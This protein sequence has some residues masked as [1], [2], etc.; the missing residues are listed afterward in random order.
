M[1]SFDLKK[2][3]M[4]K[5]SERIFWLT[6]KLGKN[7][8]YR[9]HIEPRSSSHVPREESCPIPLNYIDVTRSTC[10]DLEVAQEKRIS[11]YRDVDENRNLS[12]SWTNFTIFTLM[13]GT[14]LTRYNKPWERLMKIQTTSR[15]DHKISI[16]ERNSSEEEIYDVGENWRKAETSEAKTNSIVLILQGRT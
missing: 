2:Q 8:I 6:Q 4:R 10:A 7:F 16:I 14:P 12:G 15:P 3:K 5:Q 9:H 11:D 1:E 13:N